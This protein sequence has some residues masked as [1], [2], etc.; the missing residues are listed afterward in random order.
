[1]P[2]RRFLYIACIAL[3]VFAAALVPTPAGSADKSPG[4]EC[5]RLV[6]LAPSITEVL[7]ALGLGGNVVGVTRY[8]DYP[9]EAR[10]RPKVGGYFDPS[11]EAVLTLRPT[12]VVALKEH[13]RSVGHMEEL[14]METFTVDHGSVEGIIG[15]IEA[16]GSRCAVEERSAELAGSLTERVRTVREK[17]R[18]LGPGP[19]VMVVV[20]RT[21]GSGSLRGVYISGAEGFYHSLVEIA[22]GRNAYQGRT[23]SMPSL[24][25]EGIMTL[26]PDVII[27]MTPGVE[28]TGLTPEEVLGQWKELEGVRAVD[29]GRVHVLAGDYSVRPGPRFVRLL[30]EMARIIHPEADWGE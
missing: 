5:E 23:A 20:G 14:G 13:A 22:G 15:S 3:L 7:F 8:C 21:R 29:S 19:R 30:E 10:E 28:T 26:Q 9:P 6:S 18:G 1:M 25:V 2:M 17:V 12:L 11:F 4:A 24:S 16:L 27:E